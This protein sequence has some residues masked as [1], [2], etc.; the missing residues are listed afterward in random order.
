MSD[1]VWVS[2]A[3]LDS[4]LVGDFYTDIV[5]KD[6]SSTLQGQKLN[7]SGQPVPEAMCPKK[8]WGDED[9]P[10]FDRIPD[11]IFAQSQWIVSAQ[12]ANVLRRFNLGGGTLYPV[13]DGIYQQDQVTRVPGDFF[14][15]IFGNV[16]QGFLPDQTT[17]KRSPVPGGNWWNIPFDLADDDIAVSRAVLGGA[18]VWIDPLLFK[19]IFLSRALGDALE[20]AGLREAFKLH[21]CRVI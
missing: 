18:D 7:Q 9:A 21:R 17:N 13:T 2:K 14:V 20:A 12:A 4:D 19:S 10:F 16:K 8:I 6:P 3:R 1:Y 5:V 11:L 15:W